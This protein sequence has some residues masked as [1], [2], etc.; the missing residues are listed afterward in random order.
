MSMHVRKDARLLHFLQVGSS[1]VLAN[2]TEL[3]QRSPAFNRR[4]AKASAGSPA[5]VKDTTLALIAVRSSS[6]GTIFFKASST[7]STLSKAT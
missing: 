6:D 2:M 3:K 5:T 7:R 1:Q 4:P